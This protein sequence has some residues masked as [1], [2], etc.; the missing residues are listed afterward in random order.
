MVVNDVLKTLVFCQEPVEVPKK[1]EAHKKSHCTG[2]PVQEVSGKVE[3]RKKGNC[4]VRPVE[5]V[6]KNGEAHKTFV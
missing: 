3:T 2:E 4:T 5:E 1:V 6:P